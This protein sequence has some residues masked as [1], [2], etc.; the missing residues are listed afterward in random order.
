M[1]AAL[2]HVFVVFLMTSRKDAEISQRR[3]ESLAPW[4]SLR[5][6]AGTIHAILIL[7]ASSAIAQ[8]DTPTRAALDEVT[9]SAFGA[10]SRLRA[11]ASIAIL[12]SLALIRSAEF[13][14]VPA[15]N[16]L[17]GV[18]MDERSPG[19]YR[20]SLR[21]STLRSPFGVRNVKIYYDD[22]PL[23]DPGG[24]TYFNALSPAQIGRIEI[25]KGPAGSLYGAGTGGVMLVESPGRIERG[26][27]A[28]FRSLVGAYG[29][30]QG[31]ATTSLATEKSRLAAQYT[32][33]QLDG[34]REQSAL[35]HDVV[36]LQA[37]RKLSEKISVGSTV[38]F[39]QLFYQ[40][41][42][43]LTAA[44][45]AENPRG[46]RP[47]AGTSPGAEEA[48][49]HVSQTNLLAGLRLEWKASRALTSK[50]VIYGATAGL[51]NPAIR[52]WG[53]VAETH[54]GLRSVWS[55][56]QSLRHG[57]IRLQ[58]GGEYQTGSSDARTFENLRG[59]QGALLGDEETRV[60]T[61]F[62]FTQ[63]AW[64]SLRWTATAGLSA[65]QRMLRFTNR[66]MTSAQASNRAF[67]TELTPRFSLTYA[68]SPSAS[69]YALAARG[70]S[71]PSTPELSPTGSGLNA[72]LRAESGWNY[73]AGARGSLF[74]NV[75]SWDA[76]LFLFRLNDAIVARRDA[77][78]GDYFLNAGGTRQ[79]GLELGA[80]A[81]LRRSTELTADVW[82][83]YAYYHFRYRDFVQ[84]SAVQGTADFSGNALPGVSPHTGSAGVDAAHRSGAFAHIT[85]SAASA[86]PLD[87]GNSGERWAEAYHVLGIRAGIQKAFGARWRA[88][89]SVG[90]ENLADQR[91]SLG[92]DINAFGGRFYNPAA[93][94]NF[95]AGLVVGWRK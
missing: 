46:A 91:Y 84:G 12:D 56:E 16:R 87:D 86:H 88:E 31:T 61:G 3:K 49:A 76:S 40:T 51:E 11:P 82:A 57:A 5:A 89:V 50:T 36:S 20:I 38:L 30:F 92:N 23:T 59:T 15:M 45:A 19:S 66:L 33:R 18:R 27:G 78:G 80:S 42:G 4:R 8:T 72:S 64:Q 29:H 73:E 67:G 34:Y 62:L 2:F 32:H 93:R 43:A 52:N 85:Y 26:T 35:R 94:R 17:P 9:V 48:D 22:I 63:A 74:S 68:A 55:Y 53:S 79:A 44:E 28:E 10:T 39:S 69:L 75:L 21:G 81:P 83:S 14:I 60:R 58:A 71:P 7:F 41:P 95:Y 77:L 47:F 13:S 70:F 37:G 54:G 25:A 1:F 90:A 6:F 65:N 24:H